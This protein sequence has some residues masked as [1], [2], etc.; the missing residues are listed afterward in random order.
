MGGYYEKFVPSRPEVTMGERVIAA[1]PRLENMIRALPGV[2]SKTRR[3]PGGQ[4]AS[5]AL[6]SIHSDLMLVQASL[7]DIME[8]PDLIS[9]VERELHDERKEALRREAKG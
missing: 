8:D 4:D 5:E 3:I 9:D 6:A 2:I 7:I 1:I